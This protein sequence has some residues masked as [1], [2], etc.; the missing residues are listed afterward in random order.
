MYDKGSV[1]MKVKYG[2]DKN[3]QMTVNVFQAAIL[4][5][6]NLAEYKEE[7][8]RIIVLDIIK[9]TNMTLDNFREAMRKLCEPK[10]NILNKTNPT[11]PSFTHTDSVWF[12]K[13]FKNR[14]MKLTYS[15]IPIKSKKKKTLEPSIENLD[16]E[17]RI[18]KER[19]FVIQTKIVKIMK[20]H[21]IYNVQILIG[22]VADHIK[23]F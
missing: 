13:D 12:N 2:M 5:M 21:K 1:E 20:A 19:A 14:A 7:N 6:F 16:L 23:M 11:K 15:Y 18:R 8:S 4:C 3:Y 17:K 10:K 9:E 22:V